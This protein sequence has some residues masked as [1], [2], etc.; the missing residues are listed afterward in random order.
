MGIRRPATVIAYVNLFNMRRELQVVR[1][2]EQS[3]FQA[4]AFAVLFLGQPGLGDPVAARTLLSRWRRA[5]SGTLFLSASSL[6]ASRSP[7]VCRGG[8]RA[9][10]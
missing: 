10:R 5:A 1:P 7:R 4:P 3:G 8:C 6:P 2:G 9:G